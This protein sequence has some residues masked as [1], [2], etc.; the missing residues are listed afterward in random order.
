MKRLIPLLSIIILSAS[1]AGCGA[2]STSSGLSATKWQLKGY[3]TANHPELKKARSA[4]ADNSFLLE[5]MN[6]T[7]TYGWGERNSIGGKYRI[8]GSSIS[9]KELIHTQAKTQ[10]E[11]EHIFF[12]LIEKATEYAIENKELYLYSDQKKSYLIFTKL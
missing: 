3:V 9:F 5:F 4:S 10:F 7:Q 11:D 6:Q 8:S 2:K 1:L 12:E